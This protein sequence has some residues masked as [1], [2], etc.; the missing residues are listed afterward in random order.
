[1]NLDQLK[2]ENSADRELIQP[3]SEDSFEIIDESDA[4][5]F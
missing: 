3:S 2:R 1:M 4:D 5:P